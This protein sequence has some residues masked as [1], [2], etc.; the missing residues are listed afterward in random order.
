MFN[1]KKLLLSTAVSI[2]LLGLF[3][4]AVFAAETSNQNAV[5]TGNIVNLRETAD[6]SSKVL[7]K[8]SKGTIVSVIKTVDNWYNVN[9]DNSEGWISGEYI[10]IKDTNLGYWIYYYRDSKSKK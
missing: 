9:Y 5:I 8:L 1:L 7:D 4:G 10:T 6:T 3:S 2:T